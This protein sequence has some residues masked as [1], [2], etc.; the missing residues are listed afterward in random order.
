MFFIGLFTLQAQ[1]GHVLL[2]TADEYP[3]FNFNQ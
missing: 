2:S 3:E 1:R